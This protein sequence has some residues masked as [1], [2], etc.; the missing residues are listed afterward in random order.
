MSDPLAFGNSPVI[1]VDPDSVRSHMVHFVSYANSPVISGLQPFEYTGWKDE[2]RSWHDTCYIH[3]N[4]NPSPTYRFG[5]PD[6]IEFLKKYV[7][8]TFKP[9]PVGLAKHGIMCD[10]EGRDM[11][12]GIPVRIMRV[13]MAG[14]LAYEVHGEIADAAPVYEKL[15]AA[16]KKYGLKRLGTAAY[17]MTHWENGF[18]QAYLDFPLPWYEDKEFWAWLMERSSGNQGHQQSRRPLL[19]ACRISG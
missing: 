4:L 6:S 3:S 14:S 1:P 7:A 16:G 19:R 13:G 9:F 15:L 5:G 17:N 2:E 12:D 11:I 18:P 8:N 10:K